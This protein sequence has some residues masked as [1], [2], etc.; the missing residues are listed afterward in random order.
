MDITTLPGTE[1]RR[2]DKNLIRA[3]ARACVF[4]E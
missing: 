3:L 2:R 4:I 1:K